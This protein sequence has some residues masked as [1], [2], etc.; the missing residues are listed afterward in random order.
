MSD[1]MGMNLELADFD[2]LLRQDDLTETPVDIQ[3]FVQDKEYLGLPPLSDIQLEIVRHSTQIYKERTLISLLGEEEGKRWYKTYTDNEV[4]C[5]LGKGSGKDHCARIS[6][7]YTVYLI[8]CLRDPLIYYGKAHGVYIDLL[9]LAVNAQ[10]A[11]RVF[12]EPLKNLL[13]RSPYFN[14][15]GFEPRVSEIFFFSKPVRCFSGHSESEGWEGYEVMT[16]ILDEIAA[17][18]TDAEL[19]GETRSKGSASAIYNMSKLSIMSRFP[20]V[21]KVI[22]LSFP[23]Y[24]GDFIQQRYFNS[25][26]KKE[27]KTWTIKAATWEVNP[28]IK[29]EQLESE[30]VRNPVEARARFECEPPNMED[31]YFRDPELVRKAFMYSEDPVDEEGNFKPWFNKTDGQVR[32]IHIDLALKRDRAALSMVHCTG[33]KEVK[34]LMGVENLPII[35]VDLV[36]SWEA[37]VN[38]EINFASIRQM[39]IDLCRK[40]D[41]AKV[42]FDRWQSIEMIQSLRAQN[43]NAD[44]HSVKKTDFDTLMTAI[45]DTR[46]RGYWNE[47]LVEEE[48]LK[49]RLFGNNKIDHPSSGSKDLADAVAGAVFVCVENMAIDGDV[50]IEILSPDKYWEENE[51]IPN[52]GTVQVYNRET[53]EFSSGFNQ[54]ETDGMKW[55]ENL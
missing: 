10:Q 48:L 5:M 54:Q 43:I 44:F 6:M 36:Y 24:K 19:R 15:V 40:F 38:Q 7:A 45:Y 18:K 28:T 4:I 31:A 3:T 14:K 32:F 37:S 2:R 17:F 23:R 33:L 46:L 29:R 22:L 26:E 13:L 12:F 49:L 47:L 51:D 25:R 42:T 1:F 9:N 30:Y 53:G 11:Q 27:P 8:H 41:V 20:E 52:F 55:L 21:G 39:I 16:I 35:N 34:T 50:E